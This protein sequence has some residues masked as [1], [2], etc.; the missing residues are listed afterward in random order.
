MQVVAADLEESPTP[1]KAA[2]ACC[3]PWAHTA[4][5]GGELG[6]VRS[7]TGALLGQAPLCWAWPGIQ[8][9]LPA[10]LC[11]QDGDS[12]TDVGYGQKAQQRHYLSQ[13]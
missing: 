9:L 8:T 6:G 5:S 1:P 4:T 3:W 2:L 7:V 10:A 11:V 13:S 12:G